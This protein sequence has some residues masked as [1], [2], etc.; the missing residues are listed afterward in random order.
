MWQH[1]GGNIAAVGE[2]LFVYN[3]NDPKRKETLER[4]RIEGCLMWLPQASTVYRA[5][6]WNIL[7]EIKHAS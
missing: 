5:F 7:D 3:E 4:Q 1:F 6:F 2:N